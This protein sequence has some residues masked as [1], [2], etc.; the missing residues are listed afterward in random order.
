MKIPLDKSYIKPTRVDET[1]KIVGWD[2]EREAECLEFGLPKY[3]LPKSVG[4]ADVGLKWRWPGRIPQGRVTEKFSKREFLAEN[5][6]KHPVSAESSEARAANEPSPHRQPAP[7]A[8]TPNAP[9]TLNSQKTCQP[10]VSLATESRP[11][12]R[13]RDFWKT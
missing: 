12:M 10:P 13:A 5:E 8:K 3:I 6:G 7:A 11:P 9:W 2:P 4:A 1:G